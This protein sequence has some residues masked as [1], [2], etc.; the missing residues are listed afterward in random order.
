[1]LNINK[2]PMLTSNNFNIN[3]FS[4][5]ESELFLPY[6]KVENFLEKNKDYNLTNKADF[7]LTY[8]IFEDKNSPN[9]QN[10]IT[11]N[12]TTIPKTFEQNF[13]NKRVFSK[14][15]ICALENVKQKLIL[16]ISCENCFLKNEIF[17]DLAENSELEVII[18]SCNTKTKHF[19]N[20]E[21]SLKKNAKL[22][23]DIC[24][25][26][27]ECCVYNF[28]SKNYEMNSQTKLSSLIF[29]KDGAKADLN[30]LMD[31]FGKN[32]F[33]DMK[34][35]NVLDGTST[36]AFKGT[37][38]FKKGAKKS[39]G[40]EDEYTIFLS[41]GV[42]SKALPMLLCGEEDVNGSHSSSAGKLDEE[43]MFYLM[44]RGLSFCDA[45]KLLIKAKFSEI[46]KNYFDEK[47]KNEI[48]EKI[49]RSLG[50]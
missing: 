36:K 39:K 4:V 25:F 28:Y 44:S 29:E 23:I 35:L 5:D 21:S 17:F 20:I 49:D 50:D 41:S 6:K 18:F 9:I 2:S 45:Q 26:L 46:L 7:F 31:L 27:D 11:L 30:Y 43:K 10:T 14:L 37:I 15:K 47:T 22:K 16:K 24:E 12:K 3:Y 48:F 33:A 38:D 40:Y 34:V 8:Q 13:K 42:Q 32:G 19:L 1:M